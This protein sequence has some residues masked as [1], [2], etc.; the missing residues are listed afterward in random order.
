MTI[1]TY[2]LKYVPHL[3]TSPHV[4]NHL[5]KMATLPNLINADLS[6]GFTVPHFRRPPSSDLKIFRMNRLGIPQDRIAIRLD[7]LQRTISNHLEKMAELP[8][9]LNADLSKEFTVPQVAEKHGWTE[10]MA[11][12]QCLCM[13]LSMCRN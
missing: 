11:C 1:Q 7:A 10:P 5:L 3:R 8:N 4:R 9:F 12:P 2:E 13:D 6:K